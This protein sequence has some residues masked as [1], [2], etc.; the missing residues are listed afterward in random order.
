MYNTRADEVP[1][2]P[3]LYTDL[4]LVQCASLCVPVCVYLYTVHVGHLVNSSDAHF[5]LHGA[6]NSVD[7]LSSRQSRNTLYII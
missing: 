6:V 7:L 5:N 3:L 2:T 1:S 4:C